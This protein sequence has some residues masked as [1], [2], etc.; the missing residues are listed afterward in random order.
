[1]NLYETRVKVDFID[2]KMDLFVKN[3]RKY[4]CKQCF[5]CSPIPV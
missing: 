2:Q 3:R 5:I 4:G 1:M